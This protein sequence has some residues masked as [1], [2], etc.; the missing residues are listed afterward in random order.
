MCLICW[1]VKVRTARSG[2][3]GVRGRPGHHRRNH[4]QEP[5]GDRLWGETE[6]SQRHSG[7]AE[8][9][10]TTYRT[11]C[12]GTK[13]VRSP[14]ADNPVSATDYRPADTTVP[15][16]GVWSLDVRATAGDVE[17]GVG[18]SQETPENGRNGR[19]PTTWA[20]LYDTGHQ[21]IRRRSPSL[22][23]VVGQCTIL[24]GPGSPDPP[25]PA[26]RR[27]R[28][29]VSRLPELFRIGSRSV[30]WLDSSTP[31]GN[32]TQTRHLS[33]RAV[34]DAVRI[35]PPEGSSHRPD[36]ATCP[37]GRRDMAGRPAC[38][39]TTTGSSFWG[40]WPSSYRW[41]DDPGDQTKQSWVLSVL[42]WVPGN[43]CGIG[44]ESFGLTE[45]V[46]DGVVRG[47]EG[48]LYV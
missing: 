4:Q 23:D 13:G 35:Q 36:L 40:P 26:T 11:R 28:T 38:F 16:T 27:F 37:G 30:E 18:G 25:P 5:A 45:R 7:G 21:S 8:E 6:N 34:E 41:T 12:H 10:S 15:A 29:Q 3:S 48:I 31:N 47:N 14:G 46:T 42:C 32:T 2:G 43:C 22:E 19:R 33:W 9:S 1:D 17:A 39:Y 20:A 24:S 44:L